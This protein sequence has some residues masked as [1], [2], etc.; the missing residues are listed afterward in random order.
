MVY[1]LPSSEVIQV[2]PPDPN[3]TSGD[4][5]LEHVSAEVGNAPA[6]RG[7]K[8]A[9]SR[10]YDVEI[11]VADMVDGVTKNT[12]SWYDVI[13]IENVRCGDE[14][15]L[16]TDIYECKSCIAQY[17]GEQKG[18]FR[19]WR[20]NH[21]N[22]LDARKLFR[23]Q[24]HFDQFDREDLVTSRKWPQYAFVIYTVINDQ[25]VEV[26]KIRVW[27]EWVDYLIDDW[28]WQMHETMG[29][30]QY[31]DLSWEKLIE[32][33]NIEPWELENCYGWVEPYGPPPEEVIEQS[34]ERH[35]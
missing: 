10:G 26:A 30:A 16:E 12:D 35:F 33:L 1:I 28:Q 31:K 27:A 34:V 9:S 8:T 14:K 20:R 24:K 17:P 23:P 25:P 6:G 32:E 3:K 15:W 5:R 19:I 2:E 21:D 4:S 7:R 13:T 11:V 18:K 29:H 22:L